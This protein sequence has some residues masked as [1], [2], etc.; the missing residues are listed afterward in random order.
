[1]LGKL[2]RNLA[3]RLIR[4]QRA[5]TEELARHERLGGRVLAHELQPPGFGQMLA[6]PA[7]LK[8]RAIWTVFMR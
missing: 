7:R 1:M 5:L 4:S 8:A 3:H 2:E 6:P